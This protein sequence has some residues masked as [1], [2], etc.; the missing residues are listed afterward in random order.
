[1]KAPV[2]I[3]F[4]LVMFVFPVLFIILLGPAILSI[5]NMQGMFGG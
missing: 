2:K 5:I 4:P 3:I 1:M